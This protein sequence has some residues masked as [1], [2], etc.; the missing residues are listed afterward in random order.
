MSTTE[1][2]ITS[3]AAADPETVRRMFDRLSGRYDLFNRLSSL[4]L[5]AVWRKRALAP[6]RSG[7]S[8]LDLGAGTGDLALAA[9]RGL[10]GNGRVAGLDFSGPMLTEARKKEALMR[11]QGSVH[12]VLKRAEEIPFEAER[13]DLVVSGFVLRNIAHH[14]KEILAGVRSAM[15]EGGQISF[16]DLT[17][18]S[19]PVFR[20]LGNLYLKG[21]VGALGRLIFGDAYPALYL[22]ESMNRFYRPEELLVLLKKAGFRELEARSY[23]FGMVTHYLGRK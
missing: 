21:F 1:P 18:P 6:L 14:I 7:M 13:Y 10:Q 15:K 16:V 20:L 5:D 3:R 12:W 22:K 8:V 2:S 17:L 4:G 11:L 9:L 23:L 19:N